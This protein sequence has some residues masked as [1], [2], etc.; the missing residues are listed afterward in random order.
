MTIV[1][2]TLARPDVAAEDLAFL[3]QV[4]AST[5]AEELAMTGWPAA[6][7]EAFIDQQFS[8]Q[9]QFYLAHYPGAL[10][11][12]I[13]DGGQPAGRLYLHHRPAEIRIME[14][15]LLPAFRARGTGTHLLRQVQAEG[16]RTGRQV[17]IHVERFNPAL[18][19]YDRLNFH[20][21]EDRGVYLFLGWQP[22]DKEP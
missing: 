16:Q 15:S 4:Y 7:I 21:L 9:H 22:L 13:E 12:I 19:L 10:F 1:L 6:Q 8:A 2:R 5:R 17:T 11:T 20:L 18:R 14:L 3:R